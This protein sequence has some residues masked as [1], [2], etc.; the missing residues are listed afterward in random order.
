MT[1]PATETERCEI[2]RGE[3]CNS[4]A[5]AEAGR[6]T[7]FA[8]LLREP[9]LHFLVL[10]GA[11]FGLHAYLQQDAAP[12][13]QQIV[14]SAGKVEHLAAIF[15]KTWQRPP[16][17]QELEGLVDD[18]V[19]EEVAY[20]EGLKFGLDQ[21]DTIIRRRIRQKLDFFA[22]DL[23]SLNEPTEAQ[24]V[25]FL[26]AHPDAYRSDTQLSFRQIF[27]DP[28]RRGGDSEKADLEKEISALIATLTPEPS[29]TTAQ[30]GD[31]TLLE[32]QY[33][34]I[35]LREAAS[36]FGETFAA[37]IA[38]LPLQRWAGPTR[39]AY[40]WHAVIVDA[41]TPGRLPPL[42]EVRDSVRRDWERQ[43]R[44]DLAEKFYQGLLDKYQISIDWPTA[45][46]AR[47]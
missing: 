22:E 37:E 39:S 44:A 26:A 21:D 28:A 33:Q 4:P 27:F 31:Q 6:R 42:E 12:S 38:Q 18:Y 25:D 19:R 7:W 43:Q 14:V 5:L 29:Q 1:D 40:G 2:E 32:F 41:R 17:R 35:S 36:V 11:L 10:G 9:L 30:L 45:A 20:R 15:S 34:D 8:L 24:L 16:T 46:D 13:D 47:E 3:L 23:A